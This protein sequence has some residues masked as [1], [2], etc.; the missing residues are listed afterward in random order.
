MRFNPPC[1]P[2]SL[3]LLDKG[4]LAW[5]VKQSNDLFEEAHES[6]MQN[7]E[8]CGAFVLGRAV[9]LTPALEN[10]QRRCRLCSAGLRER[11]TRSMP[12]WSSALALFSPASAHQG[13][14][15]LLHLNRNSQKW[16]WWGVGKLLVEPP[17]LN[18]ILARN[19]NF[20]PSPTRGSE[21][22]GSL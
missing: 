22:Q 11:R 20:L 21:W 14:N 19:N 9:A 13:G 15:R 8:H 16:L 12:F 1:S 5:K 7:L 18:H 4:R 10:G 17:A 6:I 3:A 2:N